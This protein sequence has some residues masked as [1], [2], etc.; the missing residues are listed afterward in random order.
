MNRTA[1]LLLSVAGALARADDDD[2]ASLPPREWAP[3]PYRTPRAGE[4]FRLRVM[5][6]D[7]PV[8]PMD[9]RHVSAWEAG[10]SITWRPVQDT[11]VL[12]FGSLYY[13]RH[14]SDR[15]LLRAEVAGLFNDVT[16]MRRLGRGPLE[17]VTAFTS[18]T[19]PF[20]QAEW[21]DGRTQLNQE[22]TWGYVRPAFGLGARTVMGPQDDN[23]VS[24]DVLVEPGVQFFVRSPHAAAEFRPPVTGLE[25]R[26][27]VMA[28]WDSVERNLL[29]L[30]HRG[31]AAGLD[32]VAGFRPGWRNWGV[33]SKHPAADGRDP[34]Y[35]AAYAITASGLPGVD[36][37]RH[38]LVLSAHGAVGRHLDRFSAP[39][40][41]GGV[42]PGGQEFGSSWRPILPGAAVQEFYPSRYLVLVGEYRF[43]PVFFA[44]LHAVASVSV[45]ERDRLAGDAVTSS[46]DL[47]ASVG[48][49][50]TSGFLFNTR[51]QLAV[52]RNTSVV[53]SGRAGGNELVLDVNGKF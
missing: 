33:R 31:L 35:A 42:R 10:A 27:H 17:L 34:A 38:R 40:V 14:E 51:I 4:G 8:D 18:F 24:L 22:L 52:H 44:F 29:G 47:F 50:V 19:V 30:P 6:F 5:G 9:R 21:V 32:V 46:D 39:R 53:R 3:E 20:P 28:R 11:P 36:S 1:A 25:V 2:A 23:M 43:E 45:L 13:W 16:W 49:M 41:G 7:V 12:P 48:A 26:A 37:E 15:D